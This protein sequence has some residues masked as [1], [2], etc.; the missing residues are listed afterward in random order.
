[1]STPEQWQ[2]KVRQALGAEGL[3]ASQ[4]PRFQPRAPQIELAE[5]I[6]SCIHDTA[7]LMAEA[8]TGTGKTFAYLVPV[9]Q[10]GR[11]AIISTGT[12]NLQ[13]QLFDRDLPQVARLLGIN[14]RMRLLKGRNNYLCTYRLNK[15]RASKAGKDPAVSLALRVIDPWLDRTIDGDLMTLT[16]VPE[17][18]PIWPHLRSTTDNCLGSEC[19]DFESC[20][21]VRA[22]R[23]AQK[24]DVLVVNHHLLFADMALKQKEY[25]ELLPE[26]GVIVLD[27]AHQIPDT[28]SRFFTDSISDRQCRELIADTRTEA[29]EVT[30]A[31][32]TVAEPLEHLEQDVRQARYLLCQNNETRSGSRPDVLAVKKQVESLE[33]MQS[34]L[35][36][37]VKTLQSL[38]ATSTGMERVF[39]RARDM[40]HCLRCW[41]DAASAENIYW[42]EVHPKRFVLHA[43]PLDISKPLQEFRESRSAAWVLTSATLA[44]NRQF[45]H[46]KQ[47]TGLH[48][49]R[50]VLVDSPFDYSRQ[51][52]LYAPEDMPNPN[53]R[54]Y[55]QAVL[56]AALPVIEACPGGVFFLFT[57]HFAL[58]N[59]ARVLRQKLPQRPLFVQG[60]APRHHLLEDFRCAGNGVLLGAASFWEGVDVV[61]EELSC[62]IID[63]LPFAPPDDPVLQARLDRIRESGGSP[64]SRYQLPQAAIALKQGAGRLIRS[65]TDHGVLMLCDPRLF[66]KGY[67]KILLRSLPPVPVTRDFMDIKRFFTSQ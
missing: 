52:L 28:A 60:E 20:Y 27:E 3:F 32:A 35:E 64:F 61:G 63:R 66:T 57:S 11:T 43:T 5:A 9:L 34:S 51:A 12:K 39:A 37:L 55:P 30:G 24:A 31:L 49:A 56:R 7:T 38:A 15:F 23:R 19:P 25:G 42:Y 48:D 16:D 36:K 47:T 62:V 10:S 40:G 8:G 4:L 21:L 67:G 50:T 6:A 46:F 18:S 41:L 59:A 1:M 13:Q 58:R 26:A 29:S 2:I 53:D 33:A 54:Q 14:P 22:R 44:V 45:D 65:T 17:D